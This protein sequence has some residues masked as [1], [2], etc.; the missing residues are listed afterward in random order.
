[1]R[2]WLPR[3]PDYAEMTLG[4][5]D[6]RDGVDRS[7]GSF[8]RREQRVALL[9]RTAQA[10]HQAHAAAEAAAHAR[11]IAEDLIQTRLEARA[12]IEAEHDAMQ[13]LELDVRRFADALRTQ[14]T[15]P[16]V[17][18]RRLKSTVDPVVY[19]SREHDATDVE[20]RRAVAAEVTRWF[21]EAYYA[22]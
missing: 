15:P 22:A 7:D 4:S 3:F 16:E 21:V 18:V 9:A 8:S 1:M 19:S 14:G 10:I 17:A 5:S 13:T 11:D 12:R 2:R 6:G 20:W